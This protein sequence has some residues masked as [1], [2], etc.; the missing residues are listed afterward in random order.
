M[1]E[2]EKFSMEMPYKSD[3]AIAVGN[4]EQQKTGNKNS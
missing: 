3:W 2:P 4:F 1:I